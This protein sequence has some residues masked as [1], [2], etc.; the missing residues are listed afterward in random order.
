L[1]KTRFFCVLTHKFVAIVFAP[2]QKLA[3]NRCPNCLC[4]LSADGVGRSRSNILFFFTKWVFYCCRLL[5]TCCFVLADNDGFSL[6]L[7]DFSRFENK[8]IEKL[9]D[10]LASDR[11]CAVLPAGRF[12]GVSD[13]RPY[14]WHAIFTQSTFYRENETKNTRLV[15]MYGLWYEF[16]LRNKSLSL[17]LFL[18]F[19][20]SLFFWNVFIFF[21][22]VILQPNGWIYCL[23]FH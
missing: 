21:C 23:V 2:I 19:S 17:S 18:S 8:E 4:C 15:F 7:F 1:I 13:K 6:F 16:F 11:R 20:F 14:C 3:P 5:A 22:S 9:T 12:L 10:G